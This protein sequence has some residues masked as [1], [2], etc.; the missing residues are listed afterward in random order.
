MN[1][2]ILSNKRVTFKFTIK[3]DSTTSFILSF[4]HDYFCKVFPPFRGG[5]RTYLHNAAV[6]RSACEHTRG[7]WL[8]YR[9][10]WRDNLE[11]HF[12]ADDNCGICGR[13]RRP[14]RDRR[15]RPYRGADRRLSSSRR[16]SLCTTSHSDPRTGAVLRHSGRDNSP[17]SRVLQQRF[18]TRILT[19]K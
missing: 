5:H 10:H 17:A 7:R 11:H 14:Y 15:R 12:E 4:S 19:T 9:R 6:G 13:R 1:I 3:T 2:C 8:R 18:N 16:R